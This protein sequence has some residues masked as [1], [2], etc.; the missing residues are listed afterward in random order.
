MREYLTSVGGVPHV[1]LVTPTVAGEPFSTHGETS[2]FAKTLATYGEYRPEIF[3]VARD[4]HIPRVKALLNARLKEQRIIPAHIQSVPVP[5]REIME[6]F[7]REPLAWI[8][9]VP[10]LYTQPGSS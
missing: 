7:V 1:A 8:K 2:A 5:S 6:R 4:W 10:H 9:N 3:I